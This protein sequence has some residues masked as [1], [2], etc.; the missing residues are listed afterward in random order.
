MG[1]STASSGQRIQLST[2]EFHPTK[3]SRIEEAEV[4]TEIEVHYRMRESDNHGKDVPVERARLS[5][6]S[7]RRKGAPRSAPFP[8]C[9]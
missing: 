8:T 9:R 5:S 7:T 2:I 3:F 6:L 4:E 1:R